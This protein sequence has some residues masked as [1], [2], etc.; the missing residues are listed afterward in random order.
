MA[1]TESSAFIDAILAT[2]PRINGI[3]L[4]IN[5]QKYYGRWVKFTLGHDI[6][7]IGGVVVDEKK[8]GKPQH[9]GLLSNQTAPSSTLASHGNLVQAQSTVFVQSLFPCEISHSS[10]SYEYPQ[11]Q[12]SVHWV[13]FAV[14]ASRL[15][16]SSC[17]IGRKW[18]DVAGGGTI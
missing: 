15:Y 1:S 3:E 11:V 16:E 13:D 5:V 17:V 18:L 12:L 7:T 9:P 8:K 14:G 6:V 10:Q 4:R 2:R